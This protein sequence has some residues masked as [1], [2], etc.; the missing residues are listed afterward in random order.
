LKR[1][2]RVPRN[3]WE[4]NYAELA[5]IDVGS[6]L[7]ANFANERVPTLAQAIELARGKAK[8]NIELKFNG[9]DQKL[10]ERVV[11]IVRREKFE[12]DCVI[13]SLDAAGLAEV[14]R[15]APELTT[16]LIVGATIGNVGRIENDFLSAS[17][18]LVRQPLIDELHRRGRKIHAWTVADERTATRLMEMGVDNLITDDPP[19]MIAARKQRESLTTI[20]RLALA[21]R[22]WLDE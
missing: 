3:I 18:R 1:V 4:I 15:L 17:T 6:H 13:S 11:E 16:G 19:R 5:E 12:R 9:H 20:E 21:L 10:A 14:E 8:L 7:N 2:A 22:R